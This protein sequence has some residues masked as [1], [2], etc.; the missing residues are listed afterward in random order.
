MIQDFRFL[1]R[2]VDVKIITKIY[3]C[4]LK[5]FPRFHIWSQFW[6]LIAVWHESNTYISIGATVPIIPEVGPVKCHSRRIGKKR[7]AE[8]NMHQVLHW[9]YVAE[10]FSCDVLI[11]RSSDVLHYVLHILSGRTCGK[12]NDRRTIG[13]SSLL[14][15]SFGNQM[16]TRSHPL[17]TIMGW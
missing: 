6:A 15:H 17:T 2:N 5:P 13:C 8:L 16:A 14:E 7:E 1:S 9:L 12:D 3:S 11:T 4:L 10:G